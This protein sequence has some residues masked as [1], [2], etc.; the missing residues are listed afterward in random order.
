MNQILLVAVIALG[1]SSVSA[2]VSILGKKPEWSRLDAYHN[3]ITSSMFEELLR[4]VYVPRESWWK[5]WIKIEEKE[6]RIRKFAGKDDWY[7]LPFASCPGI[8][9]KNRPQE[10]W[11]P[12]AKLRVLAREN[13]LAGFHVALDP[14]HLGGKYSE[15]E[16]RHFVI[17]EAAAVKEGD[18][19]LLVAKRLPKRL[20]GLGA[21]VSLI[22]SGK[23]PVTND[24][25]K[26]LRKE[27]EAWQKRIEGDAVPTQTK[28]ERK[29][30][31]RRRGEILFFRS[32]EIMARALK[33][34]EKL[35][36]DLVV[37]IH[38]NA[39]PW[40]TPEKDSLVERNDYHVLT[41]G[42]YLGGEVALD[43][44]RLEMLVKLLNRSHKDELSLAECMAQ[45][46]K[47]ATGLPAFN[48]KGPNAVK[49]GDTPGVWGRNL[50]ANRLYE[51]PVVFLEPYIANSKEVFSRL[52]A[53]DYEGAKFVAGKIRVSLVEEYVDA[54]VAGLV[55]H[56]AS[57]SN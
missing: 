24:T 20:R 36:P 23:K 14:G 15:M 49:I 42:A 21:K 41:N 28:K 35:K 12:S 56:A 27:A 55:A 45:S 9:V 7:V 53:G 17:G 30:L 16:G 48:Y 10:Y 38:L 3:S 19:A 50:M 57:H 34:N 18:I 54:V 1:V 6:V 44:Q 26:T 32:S 51:C 13:P 22:R 2:A 4:K 46:F 33:V 8:A 31:V 29:K 25:P 52:Q 37:C 5:D 43:N 11:R 40:P 39:A 47:R